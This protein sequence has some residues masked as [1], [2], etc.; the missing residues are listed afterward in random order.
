M[1]LG[2]GT[3]IK[4]VVRLPTWPVWFPELP[5][6]WNQVRETKSVK[7]EKTVLSILGKVWTVNV[8]LEIKPLALVA[9]KVI[10]RGPKWIGSPGEEQ[11]G[12]SARSIESRLNS[13]PPVLVKRISTPP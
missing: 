4:S 5:A 7:H 3:F 12:N 10:L 13:P 6:P 9:V 2:S 1:L 11:E 8:S